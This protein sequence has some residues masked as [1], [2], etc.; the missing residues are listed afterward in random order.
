MADSSHKSAK[1]A[2]SS[3]QGPGDTPPHPLQAGLSPAAADAGKASAA[4]LQEEMPDP[5]PPEGDSTST[6]TLASSPSV[7]HRR[8]EPL[9]LECAYEVCN[10]MGGIY[11]VLRSK[12]P[13]MVS[14]WGNRYCLIGPY[15]P[16]TAQ[17][18]FEPA[19]LVGA[20]G[21]AVKKMREAGFEV[22]YGRWLVSG[23]PHVVLLD[24]LSA[25]RYLHDVKARLW[26]DHGI[27]SPNDDQLINNVIAFGEV[28]RVFLRFLADGEAHRRQLI[29]HMHEWMAAAAIPM[30]RQENWPGSIVF[31]THATLLGRY[32]AMND[33]AFYDH[34]PHFRDAEWAKHFNIEPQHALERAA[35]HGAHVFTTVSDVTAEECTH[36]LG[37]TP[38]VLLPNGLNI[39]RF[40]ALHEFQNL[41]QLYKRELH[42]FV[43]GHF[44]PSYSFDLDNTLYFFTS[45]RYEYR[46]KGMDL[47]IESLARLNWRLKEAGTPVNV[48]FFIVTKAPVKSVNV[49]ALQSSA[50]LQEFRE[51][52]EAIQ[53]QIGGRLF[54][55]VTAGSIPDLNALVDEYWRLRLRRSIHAWKSSLP[56]SI[57]T[58]DLVDDAGDDVLNQL[59]QCHLFNHESDPVKVVF[60]PQFITSTNPLFK[61][62]YDQFVRGCH[63]GVFPSY[64]EPWG[65]T[66]L[67][68]IAL[69]VPAI[70]SDLSG[71]GSYLQQLV[72]DHESKGISVINRRTADFHRSAE[73]LTEKMFRYCQLSRR[74]RIN[75]RNTTESFSEH[76]D[77]HNLGKNY[78]EAHELALQRIS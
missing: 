57:V 56:P 16:Q 54:H 68:S 1:P 69:G 10:Q 48:V 24:H 3:H 21:N 46:N 42:E 32:L 33:P 15:N 37:R 19:P 6:S 59:R 72:L 20:I 73:E 38:D 23:R 47:T 7:R 78:H 70:T 76:F 30:L 11:T 64:Y 61:M 36:L 55:S 75:L 39:Q 25:F 71:F 27:P 28:V 65:Y 13:S 53:S 43:I 5:A 62:E 35:A 74:E 50:M 58:H 14:R 22:H 29:T 51:S 4:P 18:E 44:F 52:C 26:R 63:L 60:H 34:L 49:N 67:E 66:P 77:W 8:V 40:A 17:V 2:A 31:T 45:G 9:M 41:H 12:T